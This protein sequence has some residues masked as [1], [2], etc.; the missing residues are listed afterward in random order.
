MRLKCFIRLRLKNVV[1]TQVDGYVRVPIKSLVLEEHQNP[2]K[3]I[4]PIMW[5]QHIISL[6]PFDPNYRWSPPNVHAIKFDIDKVIFGVS[7]PQNKHVQS[8]I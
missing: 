7:L 8:Y 2:R 1:Y 5:K 6:H 4:V 3:V